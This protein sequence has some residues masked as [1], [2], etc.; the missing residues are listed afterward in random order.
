MDRFVD[1]LDGWGGERMCSSVGLR[2]RVEG[3]F[4]VALYICELATLSTYT[5]VAKRKSFDSLRAKSTLRR[6]RNV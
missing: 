1:P 2:F 5:L 4:L 6:L 3:M